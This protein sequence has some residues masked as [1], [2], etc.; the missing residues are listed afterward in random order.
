MCLQPCSSHSTPNPRPLSLKP[1][2]PII[3]SSTQK[4]LGT[5]K[6][7]PID[8]D[9]IAPMSIPKS[10]EKGDYGFDQRLEHGLRYDEA[11]AVI[12]GSDDLRRIDIGNLEEN[13]DGG[14][15]VEEQDE[16]V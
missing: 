14:E 8:D 10:I 6:H 13:E 2:L 11:N 15:E 7:K 3:R 5:K 4:C 9:E 16:V 12:G 1:S